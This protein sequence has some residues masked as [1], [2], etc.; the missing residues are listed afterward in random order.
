[1]RKLL[2]LAKRSRTVPLV[3][4]PLT[5]ETTEIRILWLLPGSGTSPIEVMLEHIPLEYASQ[6]QYEAISY[7]WGPPQHTMKIHVKNPS[8]NIISTLRIRRNLYEG[9]QQLRREAGKR[10]LWADAICINQ[11]DLEERSRQVEM[12]AEIYKTADQVVVWLGKVD[13]A[14]LT[15]IRLFNEIADNV[16]WATDSDL[17]VSRDSAEHDHWADLELPLRFDDTEWAA[18]KSFTSRPWFSRLWVWQEI[19]QEKVVF[20]CGRYQ[21]S[22]ANMDV[23]VNTVDRKLKEPCDM[24]VI[25]QCR[26]I[27]GLL[28]SYQTSTLQNMLHYTSNAHCSDSRDR[29]YA[30]RGLVSQSECIRGLAPDYTKSPM[31]L[32]GDVVLKYL[33]LAGD[34]NLLSECEIERDSSSGDTSSI[35]TWIPDFS[36]PAPTRIIFG[37]RSCWMSTAHASISSQ[38]EVLKTK[39][40]IFAEVTSTEPTRD[41]KD[42]SPVATALTIQRICTSR[43]Q[44]T[45]VNGQTMSEALCRTLTTN[46]L[47]DIFVRPPAP[48]A[49]IVGAEGY[50]DPIVPNI[51]E[52][53]KYLDLLCSSSPGDVTGSSFVSSQDLLFLHFVR[54]S[55]RRRTFFEAANG[56]IGLAPKST[57]PGDEICVI[58]GCQTPLILRSDGRGTRR[59]VGQCYVHGVME[60]EALLGPLPI[61][62]RRAIALS[63][64]Y[65]DLWPV[66][67]HNE[68]GQFE[69]EDPR[70]GDLPPGWTR[71]TWDDDNYVRYV[72]EDGVEPTF[73]DKDPRM[74]YEALEARGVK[75]EDIIIS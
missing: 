63:R 51:V 71:E 60:G 66:F 69:T 4:E 46:H 59:I 54:G 48:N 39:G 13:N 70:L 3:Y 65:D 75:I 56:H 32:Y 12:M 24:K 6:L 1:M 31:S 11:V 28:I 74:T 8:R 25:N 17:I 72:R 45:Y 44:G 42:K 43:I 61:G 73:P 16:E 21:L 19:V 23:V 64:Q 35:P 18:M 37:T 27:S 29:I 34:L 40:I 9:L 68:T 55:L 22:R 2:H 26:N 33:T 67:V 58:L 30:L 47:V 14:A 49:N 53:E 36:D 62:W 57:R 5:Q 38:A 10:A 50:V 52:A 7:A 20:M 41:T 15:A